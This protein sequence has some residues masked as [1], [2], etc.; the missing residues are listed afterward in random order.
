ML[1]LP[2]ARIVVHEGKNIYICIL[3][4]RHKKKK[5]RSPEENQ[6]N[7]QEDDNDS[8]DEGIEDY[9]IGGYHP[10]HIGYQANTPDL[11]NK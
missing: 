3:L 2:G 10:V 5:K 1:I 4:F 7:S 6:Q 9:K 8:E 11:H